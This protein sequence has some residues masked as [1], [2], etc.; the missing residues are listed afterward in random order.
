[1]SFE[2]PEIE[3][4][5]VA[6]ERPRDESEAHDEANMLRVKLKE[7]VHHEPTAEDYAKALQ[8]VEEMR[9]LAEEEPA[10]EKIVYRVSRIGHE[11]FQNAADGALLYLTFGIRPNEK[12]ATARQEMLDNS[13]VDAARRLEQLKAKAEAEARKG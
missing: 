6:K 8:A 3:K 11:F 12:D 2:S 10:F 4:Q 7:M 1:M 5:E 9:Q 13:F